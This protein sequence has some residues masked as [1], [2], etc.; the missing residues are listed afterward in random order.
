M[1]MSIYIYT[2]TSNYLPQAVLEKALMLLAADAGQILA[3]VDKRSQLKRFA[4]VLALQHA[5]TGENTATCC[6]ILYYI[7]VHC[8]ILQHTAAR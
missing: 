1:Y 5:E 4:E 6:H 3:L 8:S 2:Y 7:A